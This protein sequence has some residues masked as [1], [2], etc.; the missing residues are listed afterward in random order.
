MESFLGVGRDPSPP[1][2][3]MGVQP[4]RWRAAPGCPCWPRPAHT[5]L[6]CPW[7]RLAEP[8]VQILLLGQ[9]R[10]SRSLPPPSWGCTESFLCLQ[11]SG[12]GGS[13]ASS[14][15]GEA[16]VCACT[17][18]PGASQQ[19]GGAGAPVPVSCVGGILGLRLPSEC[20]WPSPR[21]VCV[22]VPPAPGAH[23]PV[24][25]QPLVA[26]SAAG[27]PV[28]ATS[29]LE[30][31]PF[32]EHTWPDAVTSHRDAGGPCLPGPG[33]RCEVGERIGWGQ[34]K[35]RES[36][37]WPSES[38]ATSAP[39]GGEVLKH[40]QSTPSSGG[41]R[42]PPDV[43]RV[44]SSVGPPKRGARKENSGPHT[45]SLVTPVQGAHALQSPPVT[46]E[47]VT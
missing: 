44:H 17:C 12:W 7:S 11:G 33:T 21:S 35:T 19:P 18:A 3:P 46:R 25:A 8:R 28:S 41:G 6:G 45:G 13:Q 27:P 24:T 1:C 43:T 31:P 14:L 4:R 42:G 37:A 32:P 36:E 22:R 15:R 16:S 5:T 34:P 39:W 30:M 20:A 29:S 47:P 40:R 26:V 9:L 10:A 2:K 23:G 38:P